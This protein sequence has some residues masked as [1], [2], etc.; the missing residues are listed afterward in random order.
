MRKTYVAKTISQPSFCR[1]SPWANLASFYTTI[2]PRASR[3]PIYSCL[4]KLSGPVEPRALGWFHCRAP[5][6]ILRRLIL[7][8]K[9]VF[10]S[11]YI[12]TLSKRNTSHVLQRLDNNKC[13]LPY[14][15][16]T[17]TQFVSTQGGRYIPARDA[18]A[19]IANPQTKQEVPFL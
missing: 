11:H 5:Q 14:L 8:S 1:C 13:M 16:S 12:H 3:P 4:L 9:L 18:F 2:R 19:M 7:I 6:S 15:S 17:T 10:C